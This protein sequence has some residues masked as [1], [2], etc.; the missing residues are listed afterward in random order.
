MLAEVA[1]K[2]LLLV[3]AL[4]VIASVAANARSL[5]G[6]LVWD[7]RA[8]ILE[9]PAIHEPGRIGEAL[10]RDYF[11]TD[12][13]PLRYGYYRPICTLSL[14]VTY[15]I[16]NRA[17]LVFHL[18]NILLHASC[19]L[20]VL[21][22]GL[23]FGAP[24]GAAL[25]G[26]LLFAVHPVHVESV[27]WISGRT[28]LFATFFGLAALIAFVYAASR[29]EEL[30]PSRRW[31]LIG[32]GT[33]A[34]ALAVLSKEVALVVPLCVVVLC[35]A[36]RSSPVS[37]RRLASAL[38]PSALLI[39][40]YVAVRLLLIS[41]PDAELDDVGFVS[42]VS[43]A[44]AGVVRYL[45]LFLWPYPQTPY[46]QVPS[47]TTP[48][49]LL[50]L[51]GLVACGGLIW[52]WKSRGAKPNT[53][54]KGKRR[55]K[56]KRKSANERHL[57][58]PENWRPAAFL[59]C[60]LVALL[61]VL[62][63][64]RVSS[65]SDM[66]FTMAE[67]FL[68]LPSVFLCL[69]VGLA[70]DAAVKSMEGRLRVIVIVLCGVA[71]VLLGWV[72]FG[73]AAT[74]NSELALFTQAVEAS[75]E[76][77]LP[78]VLLGQALRRAGNIERANEELD[79]A[80]RLFRERGH[81]PPAALRIT[82][83]GLLLARGDLDGAAELLEASDVQELDSVVVHRDLATVYRLQGRTA[84]AR[85]QL[86][87]ALELAPREPRTWLQMTLLHLQSN[88]LELAEEAASRARELAPDDPATLHATGLVRR[89]RGDLEGAVEA[90]SRSLEGGGDA[91]RLWLDL[92]V[93]LSELGRHDE[94]VAML[95]QAVE[96]SEGALLVEMA[97]AVA[98]LRAG[99]LDEGTE[100][101]ERLSREHPGDRLVERHLERARL[102][103]RRAAMSE[104]ASQEGTEEDDDE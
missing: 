88:E 5:E 104:E 21:A 22:L 4:V 52:L 9:N 2:Q 77:T 28:D 15:W 30:T 14:A 27:C 6:E 72:S 95:R 92:G 65:P 68:Y 44:L 16:V 8:L 20:L 25:A 89:R 50:P 41:M 23:W 19:A 49:A 35:R 66:G 101:L 1:K 47:Q 85:E 55:G 31:L 37:F 53:P 73:R 102:A 46:M 103:R 93:V 94:A 34:F 71:L 99:S 48:F 42:K 83:A 75:P 43:S 67:R 24:L 12:A 74:W 13:E 63:F 11:Y 58:S 62:N 81:E 40:G 64:V 29:W 61:P 91:E 80:R 17:P 87:R 36:N 76:G 96:A 33:L 78:R 7:D 98:L 18:T 60:A 79:H 26:A 57:E 97:L 39:V 3:S 90:F 82:E 51:I 70:L 100:I 54:K 56:G 69:T 84:L 45:W 10:G 86:E 59:V 38:S 32:G